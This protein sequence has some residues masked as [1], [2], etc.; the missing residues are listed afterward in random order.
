MDEKLIDPPN[1]YFCPITR[2]LMDDPVVASDTFSYER[3]AIQAWFDSGKRISPKTLA[4]LTDITLI[5][6]TTLKNMIISFKEL[7]E[8]CST[9]NTRSKSVRTEDG[10]VVFD[11]LSVEGDGECGYSTFSMTR[12]SAYTLIK[13]RLSELLSILTPAVKEAMLSKEFMDYLQ[14]TP[15]SNPLLIQVFQKY[16][17]AA[18]EG[19]DVPDAT[20]NNLYK[21]AEDITVMDAYIDYDIRDRKIDAGWSHPCILQALAHLKG[22]ELHIWQLEADKLIPHRQA[23]FSSYYPRQATQQ[24]NLLFID[25]NHFERLESLGRPA[26]KNDSKFQK[27]SSQE[28]DQNGSSHS[29]SKVSLL[30]SATFFKSRPSLES[31]HVTLSAELSERLVNVRLESTILERGLRLTYLSNCSILTEADFNKEAIDKF[32][33][34]KL[35]LDDYPHAKDIVESSIQPSKYVTTLTV[36]TKNGAYAQRLLTYLNSNSTIKALKN[37]ADLNGEFIFA[38]MTK[39]DKFIKINY[40]LKSSVLTQEKFDEKCNKFTDELRNY[41]KLI[42]KNNLI[43]R[44]SVHPE[45]KNVLYIE[46]KYAVYAQKL[47]TALKNDRIIASLSEAPKILK[48]MS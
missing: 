25:N 10:T 19:G 45:Q 8:K 32:A 11:R 23:E 22:M 28:P 48:K 30:E 42:G 33:D 14:E 24:V 3:A 5:S 6:N 34:I 40:S 35:V 18:R 27:K 44:I 2:E 1:E 31:S 47:Q 17:T 4:P 26:L 15:K 20:V 16:L 21:Q 12:K 43:I 39:G 13:S 37:R 38:D 7:P 41:F 9:P 46:T 29:P 36:S